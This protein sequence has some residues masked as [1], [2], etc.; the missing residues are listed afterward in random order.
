MAVGISR[1]GTLTTPL[2]NLSSMSTL[3]QLHA[4]RDTGTWGRQHFP[5]LQSHMAS[6]RPALLAGLTGCL[7]AVGEAGRSGRSSWDLASFLELLVVRW[8]PR[9]TPV[10]WAHH[11]RVGFSGFSQQEPLTLHT[12]R[13]PQDWLQGQ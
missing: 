5:A 4:P 2:H 8:A 6:S 7:G 3:G 1:D 11:G 10:P 9:R 12:H 13:L